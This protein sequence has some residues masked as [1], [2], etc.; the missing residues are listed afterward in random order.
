[1][2]KYKPDFII[3]VLSESVEQYNSV[4][5]APVTLG[6]FGSINLRRKCVPYL[7]GSTT[8]LDMN[9]RIDCIDPA[10]RTTPILLPLLVDGGHIYSPS[11]IYDQNIIET[12]ITPGSQLYKPTLTPRYVQAMGTLTPGGQIYNPTIQFDLF[13]SMGTLNPGAQIY[14]P[15]ITQENDQNI[16]S[17]TINPGAFLYTPTIDSNFI[18]SLV[19]LNPGAYLY[20]PGITADENINL[21][22][23][24][25]GSQAY[26][27][28]TCP[29][30]YT[31]NGPVHPNNFATIQ[32]A[33]DQVELDYYGIPLDCPV[34]ILISG[35]TSYSEN[36]TIQ[37]LTTSATNTLTLKQL[38]GNT[39]TKPVIDGGVNNG[40]S[41][42]CL[43]I[44]D[45][46]NIIVDGLIFQ[47]WGWTSAGGPNLLTEPPGAA[48]IFLG[49]NGVGDFGGSGVNNII[50]QHCSMSALRGGE[51]G[52]Y[53]PSAS[54]DFN[55][56]ITVYNCHFTGSATKPNSGS[57]GIWLNSTYNSTISASTFRAWNKIGVV[58]EADGLTDEEAYPGNVLRQS[59]INDCY[60]YGL[61]VENQTYCTIKNNLMYNCST[62]SSEDAPHSTVYFYSE[63]GGTKFYYNTIVGTSSY[64]GNLIEWGNED[65]VSSATDNIYKNNIYRLDTAAYEL[66]GQGNIY[67]F[68][69]NP[70]SAFISDYN[71]FS[72]VSAS[73]EGITDYNSVAYF[74]ATLDEWPRL[75]DWQGAPPAE[76]ANSQEA[77]GNPPVPAIFND[78]PGLDFTLYKFSVAVDAAL[79]VG[80]SVDKVGNPRPEP[81]GTYFDQGCFEYQ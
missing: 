32:E 47:G 21:S 14:N 5:Q 4:T 9:L 67:Q 43:W 48:G 56:N 66:A 81:D 45:V 16:S 74:A 37:H 18:L 26:K 49:R 25:A 10:I 12:L 7:A 59:E 8:A 55:Y 24:V 44:K 79:D 62:G 2:A 50:F 42:T 35:S 54:A 61:Y 41:E 64:R 29:I 71:L 11:I 77:D 30:Q 72:V 58:F 73:G 65:S 52:L 46:N 22:L 28:K 78:G 39:S 69:K 70:N 13:L 51:Y 63:I 68:Y 6:P 23:L 34:E 53:S 75:T 40:Q 60:E 76:D 19:S 17:L 27:P 36:L 33:I 3:T 38:G 80:I 20:S 31:V 57:Y 15:V 1:M